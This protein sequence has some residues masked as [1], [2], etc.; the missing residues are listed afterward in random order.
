MTTLNKENQEFQLPA[1][2]KARCMRQY[3]WAEPFTLDALGGYRQFIKLKLQVADWKAKMLSP[4][5]IVD[6]VWQQHIL[7]PAHY[8]KACRLY[9]GGKL[10][11]HDPDGGLDQMAKCKRI[12]A[13]K[14]ALKALFGEAVD[15]GVWSFGQADTDAAAGTNK[16]QPLTM[17]RSTAAIKKDMIN[18]E[19]KFQ[20][21]E[22]TSS[23]TTRN[24]RKATPGKSGKSITN[25]KRATG[26]Q[27]PYR[28]SQALVDVLGVEQL[29]RPQVV[30][31]LWEYIKAHKLQNPQ[32]KREILCDDKLK[33]LFGSTKVNMFSM[34][35][36]ISYHMI[37][38]VER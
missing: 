1:T 21:G 19:F 8:R 38:K 14:I 28:L 9:T 7:D 25:K 15:T 37:E 23:S 33:K 36:F 22:S 34:N 26:T 10:I 30:S 18:P 35:K 31:R 12:E 29:P 20:T 5:W 17:G 13:T 27:P 24:K 11:G 3:S 6:C 4:S 32:D 16:R 2:L